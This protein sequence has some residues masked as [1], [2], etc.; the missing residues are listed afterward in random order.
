MAKGDCWRGLGRRSPDFWDGVREGIKM[1]AV[2]KDGE[3]FVGIMAT[4]IQEVFDEIETVINEGS[5]SGEIV[6]GDEGGNDRI[7]KPSRW[8]DPAWQ[9]Q[10]MEAIGE[11]KRVAPAASLT[12]T[13]EIQRLHNDLAQKEAAAKCL[14]GENE[15][16][17]QEVAG[18]D[19]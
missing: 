17:R 8:D 7:S 12:L 5:E 14:A 4:P 2:W 18:C 16:R 6:Y 11:T 13:T 15:Q 1:F 10:V 9:R 3:Q 19:E